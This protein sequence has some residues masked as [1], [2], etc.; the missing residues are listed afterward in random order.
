MNP[1]FPRMLDS[2]ATPQAETVFSK[3]WEWH[4]QPRVFTLS[5]AMKDKT[6]QNYVLRCSS[7]PPRMLK[8]SLYC[9]IHIV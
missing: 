4:K 2:A 1:L 8:N 9:A 5:I 6:V 7:Y 3:Q